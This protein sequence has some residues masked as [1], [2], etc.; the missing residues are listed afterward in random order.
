[1][2]KRL[3]RRSG[4]ITLFRVCSLDIYTDHI[5]T[6]FTGSIVVLKEPSRSTEMDNE[7]CRREDR[8]YELVADDLAARKKEKDNIMANKVSQCQSWRSLAVKVLLR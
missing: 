4:Y 2:L 8:Y 6:S 1:M 3:H 5:L 7:Y